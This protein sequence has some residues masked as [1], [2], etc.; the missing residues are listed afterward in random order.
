MSSCSL[1]FLVPLWKAYVSLM[2]VCAKHKRCL[3]LNSSIYLTYSNFVS[4]SISAQCS[5]SQHL[6]LQHM[7]YSVAGYRTDRQ[8][9]S[10]TEARMLG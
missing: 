1:Y 7:S 10:N 8:T 6:K 3:A 5:Q 9:D 2:S 4:R